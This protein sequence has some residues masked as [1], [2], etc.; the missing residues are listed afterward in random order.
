MRCVKPLVHAGSKVRAKSLLQYDSRLY[1]LRLSPCQVRAKSLL[2]YDSRLYDLRLS[3]LPCGLPLGSELMLIDFKRATATKDLQRLSEDMERK[4]STLHEYDNEMASK[5]TEL[6][7]M[8]TL[9]ISK[10]QEQSKEYSALRSQSVQESKESREMLSREAEDL[11]RELQDQRV[12]MAH[13]QAECKV[14]DDKNQQL[15]EEVLWLTTEISK[16]QGARGAITEEHRKTL[17]MLR[18]ETKAHML[19]INVGLKAIREAV[20]RERVAMDTE[21]QWQLRNERDSL[22]RDS[23]QRIN[24]MQMNLERERETTQRLIH[25]LEHLKKLFYPANQVTQSNRERKFSHYNP[26]GDDITSC[27]TD[28]L[29]GVTHVHLHT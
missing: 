5:R 20:T 16:E 25:E 9:G 15:R 4:R 1:D 28:T 2:Q 14:K 12:H 27:I 11:S 29:H 24:E 23:K 18:R 3:L 13:L 7:G 21:A 22:A 26:L 8:E 17:Q 19:A 6:R 10:D